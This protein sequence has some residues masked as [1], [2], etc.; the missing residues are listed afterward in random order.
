MHPRCIS[1]SWIR[2]RGE[3]AH[4][5]GMHA[6]WVTHLSLSR[7]TPL[8]VC[9]PLRKQT[10]GSISVPASYL[11]LHYNP[12]KLVLPDL[13][14]CIAPVH[15][16]QEKTVALA[17]AFCALHKLLQTLTVCMPFCE[18][19]PNLQGL[20]PSLVVFCIYRKALLGW[21]GTIEL[22]LLIQDCS[23]GPYYIKH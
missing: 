16:P 11:L 19:E 3:T 12:R 7:S 21:P 8:P 13:R 1:R 5:S 15:S 2:I 6:S 4:P 18:E 14:H 9:S 23:A 10:M 20:C 22:S 17:A